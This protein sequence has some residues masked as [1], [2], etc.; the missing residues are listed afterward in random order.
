[1]V[2]SDIRKKF[3]MHKSGQ[4]KAEENHCAIALRNKP[5]PSFHRKSTGL[6]TVGTIHATRA[7]NG[8]VLMRSCAAARY[9]GRVG[10]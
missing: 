7:R 8:V 3:F 9:D 5:P 4:P 10:S 2:Q 6:S 1:V